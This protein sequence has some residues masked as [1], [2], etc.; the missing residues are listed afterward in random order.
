VIR[1]HQRNDLN[2]V[3]LAVRSLLNP[4]LSDASTDSSDVPLIATL[5]LFAADSK[6]GSRSQSGNPP[7][8]GRQR[9]CDS[10]VLMPPFSLIPSLPH[11]RDRRCSAESA[12]TTTCSRARRSDTWTRSGHSER[13]SRL[14]VRNPLTPRGPLRAAQAEQVMLVFLSLVTS[15]LLA[16]CSHL[17]AKNLLSVPQPESSTD[18]AIRVRTAPAG[19]STPPRVRRV[20][21]WCRYTG[22]RRAHRPRVVRMGGHR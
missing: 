1:H 17:Y 15:K 7:V 8:A 18:F 3:R 6:C 9:D 20:T 11:E 10:P 2:C 13:H 16:A 22:A 19:D 14:G 21:R 5:K 4:T 12:S